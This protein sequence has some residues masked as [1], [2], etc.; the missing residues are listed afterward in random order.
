MAELV[1]LTQALLDQLEERWRTHDAPIARRLAPGLSDEEIDAL[2]EPLELGVPSEARTWWRWHNGAH[3]AF[4]VTSGGKSF[5]SL[6]Q[7]LSKAAHMREMAREV[8]RPY[9]LSARDADEMARGVWNWDW[10][11]LCEDAVGGTLVT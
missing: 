9:R 7:C 2:A 8:T 5:S 10:L 6:E 4:I 3:D 1:R 11:P